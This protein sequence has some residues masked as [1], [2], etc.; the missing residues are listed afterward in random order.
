MDEK[1]IIQTSFQTYSINR[2]NNQINKLRKE[3][4]CFIFIFF[5]IDSAIIGFILINNIYKRQNKL[6][7]L[8]NE[9][10]LKIKNDLYKKNSDLE[11][12]LKG[13]STKNINLNESNIAFNE[14]LIFNQSINDRYIKEQLYFCENQ[15][16]FYNKKFEDRIGIEN[17]YILDKKY[18]MYIYNKGDEVSNFIIRSKYWEREE[19]KNIIKALNYYSEKKNIKIQDIYVLDIGANIGWYSILLGKY[20]FNII[21]FEPS[22]LNNYILK[23]NYCLNK[24]I[25]ITII[26]KGLYTEERKC[27]L[28]NLNKNEGNGLVICEPYNDSYRPDNL[29]R[30]KTGEIILT[31]LSNYIPFLSDKNLVMIKID[32]EGSEAKAIE[33]GIELITKYHIPFIFLEFSPSMLKLHHSDP[34]QL[35]QLFIDNG[36]KISH[37]NFFDKNYYSIE[38]ILKITK[39]QI[40]LYIVYSKILE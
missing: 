3:L 1:V 16:L 32:I 40:D 18:K 19:S 28:F 36:Y 14:D 30:N 33:G 21:S 39:T 37:L 13:N 24:E 7:D 11:Y 23:K 9:A 8:T 15:N 34:K 20:G 25:N 12:I 5:I 29:F 26:N 6:N 4:Y 22:Q 2:I 35:L 10:L 27:D 38:E 17:I 31:K